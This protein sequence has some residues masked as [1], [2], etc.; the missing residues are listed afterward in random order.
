MELKKNISV[1]L[2]RINVFVASTHDVGEPA[3]AAPGGHDGAGGAAALGGRARRRQRQ[4][5]AAP[6][7]RHARAVAAEALCEV[8][9]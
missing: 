5:R 8:S 1:Y 9:L 3:P 4:R 2:K 6:R 7:L